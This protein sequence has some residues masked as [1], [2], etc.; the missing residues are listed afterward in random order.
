MGS[1]SKIEWTDYTWNPWRGCTRVSAGCRFCY[2]FSAQ[3]RYGNDPSVVV[4]TKTW[5]QPFKW[6]REAERD[7]VHRWLVFVCSWSDFF[8]E[9]ADQWRDDAWDVIRR[10]PGLIFQILTKRPKRIVGCL[11]A[12]W[13]DGYPN[14]WLGVS[15]EDQKAAD[16]RIPILLKIPAAVRFLSCEPLLGEIDLCKWLDPLGGVDRTTRRLIEQGLLNRDQSDS[17]RRNTIDWV[18]VGGESG[19]GARLMIP[20]WAWEIQHACNRASVPCFIKQMG[21]MWAMIHRVKHPKGGDPA[22]WPVKHRVREF[23]EER[24]TDD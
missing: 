3:K 24:S 15:V 1:R 14:V 13:G 18:I 9:D 22:E 5:A 19:H 7:C 6:Q 8:H 17:L 21:S 11:P 2:M 23:P 10:C 12:D 20:E 4:R 16:E